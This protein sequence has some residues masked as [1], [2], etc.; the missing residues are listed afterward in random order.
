MRKLPRQWI[1]NVIYSVIGKP[2]RQWVSEAIKKRNAKLADKRDLM[3]ELDPEIAKA[4]RSSV[5]IN[6]KC[7]FLECQQSNQPFFVLL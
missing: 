5:N 7:S 3:I 1:I 6:S 2:F 4:F